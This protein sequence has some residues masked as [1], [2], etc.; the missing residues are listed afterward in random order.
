MKRLH[1]SEQQLGN[2]AKVFAF[3]AIFVSCLGLFGLAAFS[4][5]QRKK[6]VGIRKVLGAT[7]VELTGLL[8]KEFLKLV[9]VAIF[10]ASPLAWLAMNKW[11]QNLAFRIDLHWWMFALAGFLAVLIA[12]LTVSIH[13]VK[14]AMA[15]PVISLRSE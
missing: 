6:E 7:V 13:S 9:V 11:L 8:S 14:A 1:K 10:L 5:E 4:I 2:L 3:L 15:N 12:F